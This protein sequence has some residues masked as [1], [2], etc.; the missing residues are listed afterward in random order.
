MDVPIR[1]T[2]T[3]VFGP[4][5]LDPVRRALT[6]DGARLTVTPRLFDTLLYIVQ[7][8]SRLVERDEL[9]Q[10]IWR[11]RMVEEGNLAKA[12]SSLR[13][14]LGED[15]ADDKC[16]VT[17]PG[18]GYRLGLPVRFEPHYPLPDI[19]VPPAPAPRRHGRLIAGAGLLAL[20][21]AAGALFT[22]QNR[23]PA[24][25]TFAP[26]PNAVAVLAFT[27]MS[28]DPAQAYFSD[29][30]S[31]QLIDTLARV[32]TLQVAA[33]TSSFSFRGGHATIADIAHALNVSAVLEGSVRRDGAR[34]RVTAQLINARTGFH[35]WSKTYDRPQGDILSLQT[36]IAEAVTQ[37]LQVTLQGT[38]AARLTQGGTANPAAL[39][40]YLRGMKRLRQ[41]ETASFRAA[42]ADFDQAIAL[43]P[44][45]ARAFS[46]RAYALLNI[47]LS[48]AD[49]DNAAA[50]RLLSDG[51]AA[52]DRAIVLAPGIASGHAVRAAILDNGLL[53]PVGAAQEAARA[54]ALEPGNAGIV[55]SYGQIALDLGHVTE[56][57]AA[58]RRATVLDP[59]RPDAWHNLAY[60][61]F[62]ARQ[63][64]PALQALV[65]VKSLDGD[66]PAMSYDL[67]GRLLIAKGDFAGAVPVCQHGSEAERHRC[68]A[69]ADH[70]LG[71]MADASTEFDR[72]G[73]TQGDGGT[74]NYA[75]IHAQWGLRTQALAELQQAFRLKDP[76][77]MQ[78]KADPFLDPL[79]DSPIFR[80][81]EQQMHFPP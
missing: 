41:S 43:D 55:G 64:D 79:R 9:E 29:G 10:A 74:F 38:D 17:V 61:L 57:L 59:L 28:G 14:A 39:D 40:L 68:L 24:T 56:G 34:M 36:D 6:K 75:E 73:A 8:H 52:A 53:D 58:A 15:M 67:L 49:L 25:P 45:Y 42:Q 18:R 31:E 50:T 21:L 4:F 22:W 66:Y 23:P 13:K 81:I 5:R 11:G 16:I 63:Y 3:Y 20:V 78:I 7:H 65:H 46:G 1:E 48:A 69:I 37:S 12:I 77:L 2:G 51:M 76:N 30:L 72:F 26:P 62:E 70:G 71:K 44:A 33:R 60:V 54:I 19:S 35:Y 47:A 32:D 27:N 80:D